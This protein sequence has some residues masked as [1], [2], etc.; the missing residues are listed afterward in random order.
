M[1]ASSGTAFT[2]EAGNPRSSMTAAIGID[3][4]MVSGR[5]QASG[6]ALP[7]CRAMA[8]C[9]PAAPRSSASSRIR[10]ARGST[11]RCSGCPNPGALSPAA[12]MAAAMAA[13]TPAAS[14]PAL[15]RACASSSS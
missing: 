14:S 10:S 12:W 6:T 4:F 2:L 13:A 11:G 15:T 7:K 3:T 5:P 1:R 9:G 8:T